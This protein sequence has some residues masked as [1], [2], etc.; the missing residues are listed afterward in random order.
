MLR[1]E[2]N[3]LVWLEFE[4]LQK[5]PVRHGIFLRARQEKDGKMTSCNM[6][7][8]ISCDSARAE[9]NR[10]AVAKII[11]GKMPVFGCQVHGDRIEAVFDESGLTNECDGLLT[12]EI[13][14][15]IG[16]LHADCQAA[17]FYD[18]VCHRLANVHCGWKGNVGNI[19]AR[20]VETFI[21]KG[22]KP[23]NLLVCI[24]PSLGPDKSQFLNFRKEFPENFHRFLRENFLFDL[25]EISREQLV[26]SG[27]VP[28][29]IEFA[30]MCTYENGDDFFSYRRDKT[31]ERN[32]TIA[33][34][35]SRNQSSS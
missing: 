31:E 15:P 12:E 11:F 26:N 2:K 7:T 30:K 28:A 4:Q 32:A 6:S 27:I 22:S 3:G 9:E 21:A 25:W 20:T 14:L 35:R 10:K 18:P 16:I 23:E 5:Y 19:Y 24:S 17:I 34:L 13:D 8:K 1:K 33:S 29:H